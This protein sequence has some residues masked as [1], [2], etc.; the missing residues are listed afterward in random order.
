MKK[1]VLTG[2]I[3]VFIG[4]TYEAHA[5][6]QQNLQEL[7]DHLVALEQALLYQKP[8]TEKE[9]EQEFVQL[10][11][12]ANRIEQEQYNN[13]DYLVGFLKNMDD[14]ITLFKIKKIIGHYQ[15]ESIL[16]HNKLIH[17]TTIL[18][19][20]S[21]ESNIKEKFGIEVVKLYKKIKDDWDHFNKFFNEF[22]LK[23]EKSTFFIKEY[24]TQDEKLINF[25]GNEIIILKNFF[26]SMRNDTQQ[27]T[28]A[29]QEAMNDYSELW[30]KQKES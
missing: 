25:F 1:M 19:N 10:L 9:R 30:Q 21:G 24:F 12:E 3:F 28:D 18:N 16:F 2:M 15:N 14:T 26:S 17:L 23:H 20:Y 13:F 11:R 6:L 27:I 22:F 7:L 4:L 29:A 5:S 8:K